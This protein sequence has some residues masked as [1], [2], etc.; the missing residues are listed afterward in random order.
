MVPEQDPDSNGIG[1]DRDESPRAGKIRQIANTSHPERTRRRPQ[2][3][4]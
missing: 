1:V 4:Q 3:G 2:R